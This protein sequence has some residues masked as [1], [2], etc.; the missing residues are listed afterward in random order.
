MR[1]NDSITV[2][3]IAAGMDA[4]V[5]NMESLVAA[6]RCLIA[7]GSFGPAFGL[8]VMSLEESGKL[9]SLRTMCQ[10]GGIPGI[11]RGQLWKAFRSHAYKSASGLM[12]TYGDDVRDDVQTI[13]ELA[14]HHE[15]TAG[16]VEAA[17]QWSLYVDFEGDAREWILPFEFDEGS[18]R[19]ALA[20]AAAAL[21]RAQNQRDAGL[22]SSEALELMRAVYEPF[23]RELMS[24]SEPMSATDVANRVLPYHEDFFHRLKDGGILDPLSGIDL[25]PRRGRPG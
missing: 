5:S 12:D 16:D 23:F 11:K 3:E 6:A 1:F 13:F 22:F 4:T 24:A 15:A 9:H 19:S 2:P 7:A 17:R 8:S 14:V 25:V 10:R 21:Q 20:Q 18:A